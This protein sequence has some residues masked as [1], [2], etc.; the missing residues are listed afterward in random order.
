AVRRPWNWPNAWNRRGLAA[1]TAPALAN[2]L[3]VGAPQAGEL[4][5]I[6]LATLRTRMLRLAAEMPQG[7]VWA[8]AARSHMPHIALDFPL[9]MVTIRH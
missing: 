2:D 5:P 6:T 3:H 8:N 4:P 1:F 7:A 9:P